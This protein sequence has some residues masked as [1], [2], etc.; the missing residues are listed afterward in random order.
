MVEFC[1]PPCELFEFHGSN[2]ISSF[3]NRNRIPYKES[4]KG[5]ARRT[6]DGRGK[7]ASSSCKIITAS[8]IN[9]A[10]INKAVRSSDP[11]T[12]GEKPMRT[13]DPVPKIKIQIIRSFLSGLALQKNNEM[14]MHANAVSRIISGMNEIKRKSLMVPYCVNRPRSAKTEGK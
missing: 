3:S 2:L 4:V 12:V 7:A 11:Q 14:T 8:T 6:R 10:Y 5:A 1:N 13:L 9:D